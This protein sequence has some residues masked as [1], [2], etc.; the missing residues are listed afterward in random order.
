MGQ[1]IAFSAA[2]NRLETVM[3]IATGEVMLPKKTAESTV[4][5]S[6]EE[7]RIQAM[8]AFGVDKYPVFTEK[9]SGKDLEQPILRLFR[10]IRSH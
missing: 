8:F 5:G 7:R 3:S 2:A 10:E 9:L 6:D 1:F 4:K